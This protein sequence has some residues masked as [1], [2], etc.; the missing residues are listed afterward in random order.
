MKMSEAKK[1]MKNIKIDTN[2][3]TQS[4]LKKNKKKA[5]ALS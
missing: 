1:N 2:A 4:D 5:L 3:H